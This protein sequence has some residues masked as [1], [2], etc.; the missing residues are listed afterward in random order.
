MTVLL[1]QGDGAVD[2]VGHHRAPQQ[3]LHQPPVPGICLYQCVRGPEDARFPEDLLPDSVL[4]APDTGEGQECRPAEPVLLQ[5]LDH[6]LGGVLRVRHNI[7]DGTAQRGLDG[8]LI[9]FV[10]LDE[11]R[12]HADDAG[13]PAFLLHDPADASA[14]PLVALRE[15]S[16]GF[17]LCGEDM[18]VLLGAGKLPVQVPDICVILCAEVL[19]FLFFAADA[20][21]FLFRLPGFPDLFIQLGPVSPVALPVF[22]EPCGKS[23]PILVIFFILGAEPLFLRGDLR[24]FPQGAD[25]LRLELLGKPA[26]FFLAAG[27]LPRFLREAGKLFLLLRHLLFIAGY[28]LPGAG[29]ILF[30]PGDLLGD[31]LQS[32][33]HLLFPGLFIPDLLF[34]QGDAA[35]TGLDGNL[36]LPDVLIV[37]RDQGVQLFH[38]CAQGLM[39][40]LLLLRGMLCLVEIIFQNPFPL[41]DIGEL[42]PEGLGFQKKHIDIIL[43]QTVPEGQVFLCLFRLT[44]EG[45]DPPFQLRQN[46]GDADQVCLLIVQSFDG[47]R[48]AAL[49]LHDTRRLVEQLPPFFRASAEDPVD[50]ALPY[51]GVSFLADTRIVEELV[52]IPESAG[53]PV[54]FIFTLAGTVESSG[55]RHLIEFDGKNMVGVIQRDGHMG[56]PLGLSQL[57]SRKDNVL[58]GTAAQLFCALFPQNPPDRVGDVALAAPVGAHDSGDAVVELKEYPVGEG[59]K[60]LYL[61]TL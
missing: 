32:R 37:L 50:L 45:A 60:A 59:L 54:D 38:L 31:G 53:A 57:R 30:S 23:R 14:V 1:G 12:H 47:L 10:C 36:R 22:Q 4:L 33:R 13:N 58:H 51:D 35:L 25:N 24:L 9:L 3:I 27:V 52:D 6:A 17:Q 55:Y 42:F 44:A 41:R 56:K 11:I 61:Y 48:L 29:S 43:A 49:E 26:F 19:Q 21:E 40:L 7:L 34:A 46:V 8:S 16:Q 28:L 15:V 20:G 18:V 39:L 2:I 5:K